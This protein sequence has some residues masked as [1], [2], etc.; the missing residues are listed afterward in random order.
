[1]K[2]TIPEGCVDFQHL[3]RDLAV[4]YRDE[5]AERQA[6]IRE[7]AEYKKYMAQEKRQE[8]EA[9]M[10]KKLEEQ[11]KKKEEARALMRLQAQ[12]DEKYRHDAYLTKFYIKI[13]FAF[14][15]VKGVMDKIKEH[16]EQIYAVER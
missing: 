5:R 16:K 6:Q 13:I 1:M 7:G 11:T 3:N 8:I 14:K 4:R 9:Q 10:R 15:H 2:K 12:I